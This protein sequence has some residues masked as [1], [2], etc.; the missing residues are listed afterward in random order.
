M[1]VKSAMV[2]RFGLL[3]GRSYAV[4]AICS[5][6]VVEKCDYD[7]ASCE[8]CFSHIFFRAIQGYLPGPDIFIHFNG[9]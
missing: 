8:L 7:T 5:L 1:A 2:I 9:T 3:Q 4:D 6:Y